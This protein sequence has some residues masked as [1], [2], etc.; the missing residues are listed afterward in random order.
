MNTCTRCKKLLPLESFGKDH[1]NK[2]GLKSWCRE[3]ER[4]HKSLKYRTEDS[5]RARIK[6]Y[7]EKY[8]R[9]KSTDAEWVE[10]EKARKLQYQRNNKDKTSLC[11]SRRRA[12]K[13]RATPPWLTESHIKEINS[14]YQF[15]K[16]ING[17]NGNSYHVDHIHPLKGKNFCGLH[18]PWNLQ[19]IS[20]K[21]NDAKGSKL[22]PGIGW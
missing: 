2:S 19:V 6:N 15:R 8:Y 1:R 12:S 21:D 3:C 20:Q 9:M 16:E 4:D 10:K 11:W 14:I 5:T 7:K 22:P 18:V 13:M 17:M